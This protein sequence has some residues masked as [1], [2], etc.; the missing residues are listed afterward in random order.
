MEKVWLKHYPPKVPADIN[1]AE[2]RSLVEIF[3]R[4]C[5]QFGRR[6]AFVNMGCGMTY[7]ELEQMSRAFVDWM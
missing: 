5:C 1:P 7:T 2:Y 4:S 6:N 3:D